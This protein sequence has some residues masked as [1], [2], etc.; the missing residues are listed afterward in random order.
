MSFELHQVREAYI[1]LKS[2]IYFDSSDILLR[3]KLVEFETNTIKD[4][5]LSLIKGTPEPYKGAVSFKKLKNSEIVDKK[6]EAIK[7]ALNKHHE[8]KT[9]FQFF[10]KHIDVGFNPFISY[11]IIVSVILF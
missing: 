6:L 10:L 11:K 5:F 3:R 1:K 4:N 2:Y 9:F 8:D 7:D